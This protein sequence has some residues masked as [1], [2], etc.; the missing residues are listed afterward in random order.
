MKV[1]ILQLISFLFISTLSLNAQ[2][3]LQK[4]TDNNGLITS[5]RFK[6]DTLPVEMNKAKEVL[7]NINKMKEGDEW[8]VDKSHSE[9]KGA[10]HQHYLQYYKGI[11]VAYGTFSMHGNSKNQLE[12]SIGN[13]QKFDN[14]NMNTQLSEEDALKYAM[15]H[16]GAKIYKWQVAEE[17]KWLKDNFNESYYPIG[18]LVIVK[19][20]LKSNSEYRLAY[21]F[22]IYAHIPISRHY[23]YIDA[24][25]GEVLDKDSRIH[26][27]NSPGT[28]NTRYSGT[29]NITTDSFSGGFRLRETRNNVRIE[30][31]NMNHTG[32]Y[33]QTDF[34][35]NDNN[36]IEHN[37]ANRDNAG[38]DAH[39]GAEVVYDYFNQ[40]HNRNSYNGNGAPLLSYVNANLL[41]FGNNHSD[42]AFWDGNK[43]TYGRG[44]V[45]NP[46]TSLDV[47]AHEIAHGV[48]GNTARLAYRKES[49][50]INEALSDIWA[51]CVEAWAAPT[52]QI[53]LLG[54]DVWTLRSMNNPNQF[55]QPDTYLGTHWQNTNNCTP[56]SSN[57]NCGVHRNSGVINY[58]F[59]LLSEG[60]HG[61]NDIGNAFWVNTIGMNKAA[62]IVYRTQTQIIN[63]SV[64]QEISFSQFREATIIATSNI[65]GSTSEEVMQV[66]NAWHAVGVGNRYPM[67]IT[68][69]STICTQ[70]TYT[71]Q[72][73]PQ[74]ATVQWSSSNVNIATVSGNGA[75]AIVYPGYNQGGFNLNAV[76]SINGITITNL[77]YNNITNGIPD[78]AISGVMGCTVNCCGYNDGCQS[79]SVF[80]AA[81]IGSAGTNFV[82]VNARYDWS[83]R[84]INSYSSTSVGTY[85]GSFNNIQP[86]INFP[87]AGTYIVQVFVSI[88]G[89]GTGKLFTKTV[90]VASASP[91]FSITPNPS[92]TFIN[93]SPSTETTTTR[94]VQT[95]KDLPVFDRIVITDAMG[96]VKLQ[97][98]VR[99]TSNYRVDVSRLSN[100]IYYL[101]LYNTGKLIEK[102]TIQIAK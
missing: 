62:S 86:M 17:E 80:F 53:W 18:E 8:R 73:L 101:N 68:G 29:R 83:Y 58:W 7:N 30:T 15:K 46:F 56:S 41:A 45:H 100:G 25:N 19:D 27:T 23:I 99:Q 98:A 44:T 63:S 28:A 66:T 47:C 67:N 36:W 10:K 54:E 78:F 16:I 76:V 77:S 55:L 57:D 42:N 90:D 3:I 9:Q 69:P 2:G 75:T 89:C 1:K 39:W 34:I 81:P 82:N 22:D 96:N 97:Q 60:G 21:K 43:M 95:A 33:S 6:T 52:K 84:E 65:F 32:T 59:F 40:I 87:G 49:G 50:A 91:Y 48:T 5:I 51:A 71:I 64:E 79:Q 14:V 74:G 88:N 13:F 61:T 38:L 12:S 20:Y 26:H 102:K 4:Q 35:D 70:A 93:I 37:N 31:Y 94:T 72:N 92:S 24:I 11:R 85:Y